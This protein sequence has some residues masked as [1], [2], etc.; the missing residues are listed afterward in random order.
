VIPGVVKT[1]DVVKSNVT[2]AIAAPTA[3]AIGMIDPTV[4]TAAVVSSIV[5][6][7]LAS[8]LSPNSPS[9]RM[10]GLFAIKA[11]ARTRKTDLDER[12][13][14]LADELLLPATL[15]AKTRV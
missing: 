10:N 4:R 2:Q 14:T 15:L 8:P 5:P 7:I 6:I 12:Q 3:D 13:R 9:Q 1:N 11:S